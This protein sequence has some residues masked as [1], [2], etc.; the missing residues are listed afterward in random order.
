[1][2]VSNIDNRRVSIL[3][4]SSRTVSTVTV[5]RSPWGVAVDPSGQRLFVANFEDNTVS[6]VDALAGNV[7]QTIP[8]QQS[9][10]AFGVFMRPG[11]A[12]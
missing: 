3:D 11:T 12:P 6:V 2:Y 8:V 4:T 7:L 5:G 10:V 9:P 1:V